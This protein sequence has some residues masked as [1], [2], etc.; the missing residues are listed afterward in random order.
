MRQGSLFVLGGVFSAGALSLSVLAPV[1]LP[2]AGAYT[3]A[4]NR[5]IQQVQAAGVVGDPAKLV[6]TA[7]AVCRHTAEGRSVDE[8]ANALAQGST[9]VNGPEAI[10]IDQAY[11]MVRTAQNTVCAPQG[12][13]SAVDCTKLK[14]AYDSLGPVIDTGDA[15][16]RLNKLPGLSQV[17]G[18]SL[19]LCAIDA[20]PAAINNPTR[21]NQQRVADGTCGFISNFTSGLIDLC[22]TPVGSH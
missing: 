21:E 15:V 4:E 3:D 17:T 1:S 8:M 10:T 7:N 22:G 16:A 12:E 18:T 2:T 6:E 11:G 13:T 5:Y 9:N 14:A 19:A 20:V